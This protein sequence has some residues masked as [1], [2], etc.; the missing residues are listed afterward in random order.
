MTTTRQAML[1][2]P[3]RGSRDFGTDPGDPG[4][5]RLHCLREAGRG[6]TR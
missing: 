6:R 4:T 2:V 1:T 3:P 5:G